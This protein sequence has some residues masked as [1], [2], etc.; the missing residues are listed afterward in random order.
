MPVSSSVHGPPPLVL[1]VWEMYIHSGRSMV[2]LSGLTIEQTRSLAPPPDGFQSIQP[3]LPGSLRHSP[4]VYTTPVVHC[5]LPP[6]RPWPSHSGTYVGMVT[7]STAH[8]T[9][10]L[11]SQ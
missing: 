11:A 6:R 3:M 2:G 9:P 10:W 4:I 1:P 7:G 8:Q 5:S